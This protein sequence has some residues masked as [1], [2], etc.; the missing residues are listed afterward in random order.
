MSCQLLLMKGDWLW[1][2]PITGSRQFS[3]RRHTEPWRSSSRS[4][5]EPGVCQPLGNTRAVTLIVPQRRCRSATLTILSCPESTTQNRKHTRCWKL[6]RMK[7]YVLKR[8][9]SERLV[10]KGRCPDFSIQ[11]SKLGSSPQ[12]R[13]HNQTSY[14]W[15]GF[16]V[17]YIQPPL[18]SAP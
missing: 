2:R 1:H 4:V 14:S 8:W 18:G 5:S 12:V 15:A 16:S 9:H 7:R 6:L 13:A 10:G 17:Y 11:F 3:W